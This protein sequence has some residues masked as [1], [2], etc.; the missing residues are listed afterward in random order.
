MSGRERM[1]SCREF[2][3]TR[4]IAAE[5][6]VNLASG[7]RRTGRSCSTVES[8]HLTKRNQRPLQFPPQLPILPKQKYPSHA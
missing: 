7:L 4:E 8:R 5:L 6:P 3:R 1:N 2:D